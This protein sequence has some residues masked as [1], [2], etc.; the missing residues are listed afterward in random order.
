[1]AISRWLSIQRMLINPLSREPFEL[2]CRREAP[3]Q[4]RASCF[5]AGARETIVSGPAHFASSTGP[6]VAVH[7]HRTSQKLDYNPQLM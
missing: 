6:Q 5:F 2:S 1:M 7:I 4:G 3:V